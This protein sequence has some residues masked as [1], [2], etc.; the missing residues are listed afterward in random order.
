MTPITSKD[1]KTLKLIRSLHKKKG[2]LEAGLFFAEGVRLVNEA[3]Q[4]C[5]DDLKFVIVSDEFAA[6]NRELIE[7]LDGSGKS[8]YNTTEGLFNDICPTETPQGIAA[9][10]KIPQNPQ[11]INESDSFV[12]ILD[13]VSEPGNMGTIIRTAEAAGVDSVIMTKGCVDLYSPKVVRSAMGSLFRMKCISNAGSDIAVKLKQLNFTI[14]AT[15]LRD[16]VEI[17]KV[18]INGKRALII[19]SEA[20]GV[21]E[22]FLKL[23]DIK[24]RIPMS[25]M[26]ESLNA[27]VAAGISMYSL[28]LGIRQSDSS[29]KR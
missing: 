10:I 14:A 15:A 12:L 27:A 4:Y 6:K 13:G 16:S 17:N 25:G 2:R 23:S 20:F 24:I 19:G 3:L 28:G 26:V 9:V 5:G 1:N 22:E 8:V 21:S 18:K 11:L 29:L 7:S